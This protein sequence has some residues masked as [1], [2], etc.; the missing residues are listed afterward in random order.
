[1]PQ[2]ISAETR[3]P[4]TALVSGEKGFSV[5]KVNI[6]SGA[7][8][9]N[10]ASP[11]ATAPDTGGGSQRRTRNSNEGAASAMPATA[12]YDS[13]NDSAWT[14]AGSTTTAAQNV[15]ASIDSG[16]CGRSRSIAALAIQNMTTALAT[17]GE[18]PTTYR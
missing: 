13:L 15:S 9:A 5:P 3:G 2:Y 11:I 10:A 8:A 17:A 4:A 14:L 7:V 6:D 1:M 16:G 18:A 12:R